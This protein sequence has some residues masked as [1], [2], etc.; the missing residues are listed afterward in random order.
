MI[1]NNNKYEVVIVDS[2]DE[3]MI[4]V[5]FDKSIV[6]GLYKLQSNKEFEVYLN[7]NN[8]T[9]YIYP[10]ISLSIHNI[11]K[12]TLEIK[13]LV[14]DK[15]VLIKNNIDTSHLEK[16]FLTSLCSVMYNYSLKNN[17]DEKILINFLTTKEKYEELNSI[18]SMANNKNLSRTIVNTPPNLFVPD[19]M[20][21]MIRHNFSEKDGYKI[22]RIISDTELLRE[23]YNL[24]YNVGKASIHQSK[25]IHL[26]YIP[27]VKSTKKIVLVGKGLTYDSGGL[28]L[29]PSASM[30]TMKA[31]KAGSATVF[32]I[33]KNLKEIE[34]DV[35]VHAIFGMAENMVAGNAYKPDDVITAKNGSTVEILNTDA[36]GRLVL[37]DCLMYAQNNIPD[38]DLMIDFAT[39][40]G[41][42]V[43]GLGE[44]TYGIMSNSKK[45]SDKIEEISH[46]VN[47]YSNVLMFNELLKDSIKSEIA[48]VCNISSSRY[49][50]AMTAGLF[51]EH[52][53]EDKYKDKWVHLDIAGPAYVG[54]KWLD[55]PYGASGVSIETITKLIKNY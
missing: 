7:S 37:A 13:K 50:G 27:K 3:D 31:D 10:L 47:E 14:T 53:I 4:E 51:L 5:I 45:L 30:A 46:S 20:V 43:V 2:Y 17:K 49:G 24:M 9:K 35:E 40:T 26:S 12:L 55:K 32:G 54:K 1:K 19:T 21:E 15:S 6:K 44:Y 16:S 25:L 34:S 28:S 8:K 38:I 23:D 36:E 42:C 18:L 33:M 39:L 11:H 22:E 41:A 52:F 29:K 48:D